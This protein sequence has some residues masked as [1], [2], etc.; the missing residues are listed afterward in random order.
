MSDIPPPI[1]LTQ[2][3]FFPV[4]RP[5]LLKYYSILLDS[6]WNPKEIDFSLDRLHYQ[7]FGKTRRTLIKFILSFF[8]QFDGM[9][10]ENI[11]RRFKKETSMYKEAGHFY[12]MQGSNETVHNHTYSISIETV[13]DTNA[14]KLEAFTAIHTNPTI[15]K[16]ADWVFEWMNPMKK[17]YTGI[18]KRSVSQRTLETYKK[19][20]LERV[21]AF[22][23]IEGMLFQATFAVL[24]WFKKYGFLPGITKANEWIARDEGIH[25]EFAIALY[26]HM[27]SCGDAEI[28]NEK[29]VQDIISSAVD[30]SRDFIREA[31]SESLDGIEGEVHTLPPTETEIVGISADGLL[32]YVMCI[33]DQL[34]EAYG[35]GKIYNV[36]SPYPWMAVIS[37]PNKTNFFESWVTEYSTPV[38]DFTFDLNVKC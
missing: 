12:S 24:Y 10:N 14:E 13:F 23:C 21:I 11:F 30:I 5:G 17:E 32:E 27:T 36:K 18:D 20:L 37:I 16:I 31:F 4:T 25:C 8:S 35:C 9:L 2:Y 7:R 29:I 33:A 28:V 6:Q 19:P 38:S 3:S 26:H 34:S 22:S 15:K 1:D